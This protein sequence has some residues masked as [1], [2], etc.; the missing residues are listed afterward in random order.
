MHA[1]FVFNVA[2]PPTILLF[3][4]F[5]YNSRT[6]K[7]GSHGWNTRRMVLGNGS[8]VYTSVFGATRFKHTFR[9]FD[10]LKR[11]LFCRAVCWNYLQRLQ[12]PYQATPGH[13]IQLRILRMRSARP[14]T[15]TA[16]QKFTTSPT[17]HTPQVNSGM[18]AAILIRRRDPHSKHVPL[19][20]AVPEPAKEEGKKKK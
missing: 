19:A 1:H 3:F 16:P 17:S 6:K 14:S 11:V 8:G 5:V 9:I 15:K 20:S 10:T 2:M 18:I 7:T 4:L 12:P 13:I